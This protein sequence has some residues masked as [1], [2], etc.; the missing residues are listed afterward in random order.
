MK[1]KILLSALFGVFL[2]CGCSKNTTT[3]KEATTVKPTTVAPTTTKTVTTTEEKTLSYNFVI[4]EKDS[5]NADLSDNPVVVS[6]TITYKASESKTVT[7]TLIKGENDK[8]YFVEGGTDYLVLKDSQYGL[9]YDKGY[10][11]DFADCASET[12]IDVSY[13]LTTVN[14]TAAST[15]I[16]ATKLEGLTTYGFVIQAWK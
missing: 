9:S 10:F 4:Y 6:Y 3:T 7:D 2:L 11:K 16:G 5:D 12:E 13:S 8:Y 14:G 15:G 1:G